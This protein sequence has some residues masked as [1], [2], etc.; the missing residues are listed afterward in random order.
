MNQ[1]N[2]DDRFGETESTAAIRYFERTLEKARRLIENSHFDDA[3]AMLQELEKRFLAGSRLFDL[4]G[5]VLMRQGRIEEGIRY[6]ALYQELKRILEA[7]RERDQAYQ[8]RADT[9]RSREVAEAWESWVKPNAEALTEH[10]PLASTEPAFTPVTA[11]MGQELMRQGH[12]DRALAIFSALVER[13]PG[14]EQLR[15][16]RD[17]ARRKSRNQRALRT[18]GHWLKNL[19]RMKTD[20]SV[21]A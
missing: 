7:A 14:D 16:V 9:P 21:Q 10:Y 6:R 17:H 20:R 4:L 5:E 8:R 12:F 1:Q 18:L 2:S 13:N 19:E 3:L 15:E 11:A